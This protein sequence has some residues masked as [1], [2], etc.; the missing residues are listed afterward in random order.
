MFNLNTDTGLAV[1][2]AWKGVKYFHENN[3]ISYLSKQIKF[4]FENDMLLNL[5]TWWMPEHDSDVYQARVYTEN[6]GFEAVPIMSTA[7]MYSPWNK[8]DLFWLS[9]WEPGANVNHFCCWSKWEKSTPRS[10]QVEEI[11]EHFER[12]NKYDID[13]FFDEND[14]YEIGESKVPESK[15]WRKERDSEGLYSIKQGK[16]F[17]WRTSDGFIIGDKK[18]KQ[19]VV[20][21]KEAEGM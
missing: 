16:K 3:D 14:D 10:Q 17:K 2:D 1:V 4:A 15:T 6:M 7:E 12:M 13:K 8:D 18:Y 9:C 11:N 20:K 19:N 5:S 21:I